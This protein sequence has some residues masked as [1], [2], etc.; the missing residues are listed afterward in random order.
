MLTSEM[1]VQ[2][3]TDE[4]YRASLVEQGYEV[5]ETPQDPESMSLSLENAAAQSATSRGS[6]CHTVTPRVS[7]CHAVTPRA[8]SSAGC[9]SHAVTPRF[10]S[11][12]HAVNPRGSC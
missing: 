11:S 8:S 4:D 3:W 1:I 12:S 5:P 9:C 6:S 2:A 10:S 7:C